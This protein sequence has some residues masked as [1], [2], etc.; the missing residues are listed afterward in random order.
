MIET[1]AVAFE[2]CPMSLMREEVEVKV[3]DAF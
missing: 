2:W 3:L 1:K